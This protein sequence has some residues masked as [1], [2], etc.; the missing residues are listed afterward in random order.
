L[1]GNEHIELLRSAEE[2]SGA[3]TIYLT[4]DDLDDILGYIAF[5]ANHRDDPQ[6]ENVF[7]EMY[8][9]LS[10]IESKYELIDE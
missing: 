2:Q 9:R 3:I 1:I 8:G 5:D 7:V 10:E 4:L 6:L